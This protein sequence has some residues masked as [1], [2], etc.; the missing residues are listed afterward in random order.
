MPRPSILFAALLACVAVFGAGR[1]ADGQS[2]VQGRVTDATT[3]EPL[4]SA[5]VQLVGTYRGTITNREGRFRLEVDSLPATVE[6]SFVGYRT[7]RRSV[8]PEQDG[9]LAIALEPSAVEM[10]EVVVTGDDFAENLMRRVIERKQRWWDSLQTYAVDA[11]SRYTIAGD[12]AIVGIAESRSRAYWRRGDGTREVVVEQRR[13]ANIGGDEVVGAAVGV[14]NLYADDVE[15]FGHRLVGVTH[16]D[17]VDR[18]AFTLDSVRVRDGRRVYDIRVEPERRTLVGFRGT[19]AVLDS[20]YALLSARLRPTRAVAFPRGI[21]L[22][23]VSFRQQFSNFGRA[24]WLPVDFRARYRIKIG[25]G[26]LLSVPAIALRQV[27]RL[28]DYAVNEPVPDSLYETD[29]LARIDSASGARPATLAGDSIGI[30]PETVPLTDAERRAYREIDSTDTMEKAF[31]P[32]GL[33]AQAARRFD[34]GD[35]EDEKTGGSSGDGPLSA[36]DLAPRLWYNRVEGG[37]LGVRATVGSDARVRASVRGAVNTAAREA[38]RWAYGGGLRADLGADGDT[39]IGGFYRHGIRPRYASERYTR[40]V[41]GAWALAGEADYFDYARSERVGGFVEQAV[42]P[43]GVRLTA[44]SERLAPVAKRT[45]YDLF[46]RSG[47]L[48]PN[49]AVPRQTLRSAAVSLAWGEDIDSFGGDVQRRVSVSVEH[50]S[51]ALVETAADYTRLAAAAEVRVPTF[52][53]RRLVPNALRLRAEAGL[54]AGDLPAARSLI[55]EGSLLPYAPFGSLRTLDGRPYEGDRV[56]A[57]FWEH[58]FRSVPFEA[59]GL[60][61]LADRRWGLSVYGAH[62]AAD[63]G[64]GRARTLAR[65][66]FPAAGSDGWHHEVGLGLTGLAGFLRLNATARLDARAFSLGLGTGGLF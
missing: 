46:A 11:Y 58:R 52:F 28:S 13:T 44:S 56:A 59:L 40:A 35:D 24:F 25:L 17:A 5:T 9:P 21:D 51:D 31:R 30:R 8:G 4:P 53:R 47:P 23:E 62:A 38:G 32:T 6:A 50:S 55:V 43:V 61:A 64:D 37:H 15:L 7:A 29:R 60:F 49:P 65:R 1:P 20:T 22:Q 57:L 18:Y 36:V 42:G 39:K 48:R 14:R 27:A 19:V 10:D 2:L 3:G 34:D 63:W 26:P 66:G 16:P 12:T 45:D 41:N 33:L 54:A